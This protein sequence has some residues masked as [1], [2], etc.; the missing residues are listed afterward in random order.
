MK[1]KVFLILISTIF[2]FSCFEDKEE[3]SKLLSL[4]LSIVDNKDE[5]ISDNVDFTGLKVV[6]TYENGEIRD[7]E[8]DIYFLKN[9]SENKDINLNSKTFKTNLAGEY[10]LRVAKNNIES[11]QVNLEAIEQIVYDVRGARDALNFDDLKGKNTGQNQIIFDLNLISVGINNTQISWFLE[12]SLENGAELNLSTGNIKLGSEDTY[13]TLLAKI[14]KDGKYASKSFDLIIKKSE[15]S[16]SVIKTERNF[17]NEAYIRNGNI[18]FAE[19]KEN[20][21]LETE[22]NDNGTVI[23]W[24]IEELNSN[25][26]IEP[27]ARVN[28]ETGEVTRGR[29]NINYLLKAKVIKEDYYDISEFYLTVCQDDDARYIDETKKEV[30][31]VKKIIGNNEN[32][33]YLIS[34]LSLPKIGLNDVEITWEAEN[35]NRDEAELSLPDGAITTGVQDVEFTLK[36]LLRKGD[37][38]DSVSYTMVIKKIRGVKVTIH[39]AKWD[40]YEDIG[41]GD[42]RKPD[43]YVET[44]LNGEEKRTKNKKDDRESTFEES[45]IYNV[46]MIYPV[47]FELYDDDIGDDD[48]LGNVSISTKYTNHQKV[49]FGKG[50][51]EYSVKYY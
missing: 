38:E 50:F 24:E 2:L 15:Y 41:I 22:D 20:L 35:S 49:Y 21:V 12:K 36:A 44:V 28:L 23:L 29:N 34:D 30:L 37:F 27:K 42:S 45:F 32:E 1:I 39:K 40:D 10:R 7:V 17:V 4:N 6:G 5:L 33:N 16:A 9:L 31:D 51:I 11:N 46:D 25:D 8:P 3:A 13:L 19:I 47:N 43:L 48:K 14:Y 18:S 26:N